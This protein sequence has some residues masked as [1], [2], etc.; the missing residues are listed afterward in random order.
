MITATIAGQ[1][2]TVTKASLM[3]PRSG[4]WVGNMV[5]DMDT[6]PT[7]ALTITLSGVDM[8]A[9]IQRCELVRGMLELR[10]VGGAGGLGKLATPV[11]YRNPTVR[12]VLTDLLAV[13]GESASASCTTSILDLP[14]GYW[15]TLG[16]TTGVLL[17]ALAEVVGGGCI[18]RVSY[19]GTVFFGSETWPRCPAD[20]RVMAQD[21][22][23]ASQVLGTETLGI[24]PGTTIDGRRVDV[25]VHE[26]NGQGEPRSK[27]WWAEEH[28]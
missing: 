24:W 16:L 26:F 9:W 28:A 21:A 11:H 2:R 14:L 10:V 18:W 23:N 8:P 25:V 27:V 3:L 7:G 12:H 5:L 4:T 17:E 20:V 15:T 13:A 19:D 1:Q 6:I 22:A